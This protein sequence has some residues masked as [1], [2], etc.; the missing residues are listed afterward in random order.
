[1]R[2]PEGGF[3]SAEDAGS[4]GE[5]GKFYLWTMEELREVSDLLCEFFNVKE[6]GNIP[7]E[8]GKPSGKNV[9]CIKTMPEIFAEEKGIK[10]TE[11]LKELEDWRR[12]LFNYRSGRTLPNKDDKIL[13]DWNGLMIAAF[14]RGY[15]VLG[16]KKYLGTAKDALIICH[17]ETL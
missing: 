14:A 11:F 15:K 10:L 6:E 12:K 7:Y 13:T 17:G 5:E 16:N 8:T 9:L 3:S 2:S 4:E 1:M